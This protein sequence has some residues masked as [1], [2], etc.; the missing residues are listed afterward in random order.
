MWILFSLY[1]A[2]WGSIFAILSKKLLQNISPLALMFSV[3][4]F[5]LPFMVAIILLNGG[6]PEASSSLYKFMLIAAILDVFAFIASLTAIKLSP[7]SLI[8]P[9][10]SFT[11]VFTTIIAS[12]TINEIPTP[13]KFLGIIILVMGTYVLNISDIKSGIFAPF[14]NLLSHKG[15]QLFLLA[16][17]L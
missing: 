15:V 7:I 13:T 2:L 6:F 14:K 4:I 1:F 10:S 12:F 5:M 11:P 3:N 17:F 16:N 8:L 9:I